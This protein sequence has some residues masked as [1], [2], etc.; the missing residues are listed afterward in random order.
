MRY[1]RKLYKTAK[2]WFKK[3]SRYF[4]YIILK[5]SS[6]LG[7]LA[8]GA[9]ISFILVNMQETPKIHTADLLNTIAKVESKYNYNAYFG[10][11]TNTSIN[12]TAMTVKEVL[13]WQKQFIGQGNSSSAVG[14]YQFIDSTLQELV[15]ELEI[16]DN[17]K[18]DETLQDRLAVALLE[19]RGMHAYLDNKMSREEFAHSLS[20]EW[21][22]L[23][24]VIGEHPEQSYYAGDGLN[25]AQLSVDEVYAS[26]ATVRKL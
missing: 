17:R 11:S 8:V 5:P 19:R 2:R 7:V 6:V 22:A 12:F 21:A 13:A 10:N 3:H 4:T 14:R 15:R 23:P 18:F 26:I 1:K 20:K 9:V 24:K 25:K 16:D